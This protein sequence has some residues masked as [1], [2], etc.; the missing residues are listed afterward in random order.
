MQEMNHL[1]CTIWP[2]CTY[3]LGEG[4]I[5][6]DCPRAFQLYY[7]AATQHNEKLSQYVVAV[8]LFQG[9]GVPQNLELA[10]DFCKRAIKQ[11]V[12]KASRLL[13][14]IERDMQPRACAQCHAIETT[15]GAFHKCAAC[16]VVRY[17]G[18]A[19]QRAHWR[20]GHK[21]ECARVGAEADAARVQLTASL[22]SV[23]APSL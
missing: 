10:R 16:R 9:H 19:C 14:E 20:G 3:V 17:C 18:A 6:Q 5:A 2:T 12:E 7:T 23:G 1:P 22:A 13:A 21:G 15:L 4:V 11:G 8:M